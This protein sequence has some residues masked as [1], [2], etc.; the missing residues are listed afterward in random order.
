MIT[1]NIQFCVGAA[2][3]PE[4]NS[5]NMGIKQHCKHIYLYIYI[6][7]ANIYI[8]AELQCTHMGSQCCF[9]GYIQEVT[10]NELEETSEPDD[11]SL[12]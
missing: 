3:E 8:H 5:C 9:L 2:V 11:V 12:H 4:K 6:H 10:E 1:A 7:I